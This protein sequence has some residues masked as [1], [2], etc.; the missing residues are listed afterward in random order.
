MVHPLYLYFIKNNGI[1]L[2]LR[3][4][5]QIT[6]LLVSNQFH[7]LQIFRPKWR[8]ICKD[9]AKVCICNSLLFLRIKIFS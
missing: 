2:R 8:R 3:H 1:I 7:P 5:T 9:V 6:V 4:S